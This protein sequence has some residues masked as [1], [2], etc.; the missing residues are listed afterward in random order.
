MIGHAVK[1][2][3]WILLCNVMFLANIANGV[4]L[5]VG[6]QNDEMNPR[7]SSKKKNKCKENSYRIQNHTWECMYMLTRSHYMHPSHEQEAMLRNVENEN[8]DCLQ[9][10]EESTSLSK[11]LLICQGSLSSI[12]T[13]RRKER[14]A[15]AFLPL[16]IWCKEHVFW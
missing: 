5:G 1:R 13:R 2:I 16:P 12:Y 6:G 4:S 10:K 3:W 14:M 11:E 9:D 8:D 7:W 15:A